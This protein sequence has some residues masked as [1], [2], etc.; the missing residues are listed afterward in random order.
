MIYEIIIQD[1]DERFQFA[2]DC[3]KIFDKSD[4]YQPQSKQSDVGVRAEI[5][6]QQYK[7]VIALLDRRGY[8]YKLIKE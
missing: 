8:S 7:K 4:T 1:K 2:Q 3:R 5:T 6:E